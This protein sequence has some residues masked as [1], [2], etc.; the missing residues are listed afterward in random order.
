MCTVV[1]LSLFRNFFVSN[2]SLMRLWF[3]LR[4]SYVL[5]SCWFTCCKNKYLNTT[6]RKKKTHNSRSD[7][8][9]GY[10]PVQKPSIVRR[11]FG[12]GRVDPSSNLQ[13]FRSSNLPFFLLFFRTSYP[14]GRVSSPLPCLEIPPLVKRIGYVES[15]RA[16]SKR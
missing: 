12:S 13:I 1:A 8:S 7:L 11:P 6:Q 2:M 15:L 10:E 3:D 4:L 14:Q 5:V 9:Y 16:R